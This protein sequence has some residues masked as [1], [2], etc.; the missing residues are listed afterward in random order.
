MSMTIS[1]RHRVFAR[2]RLSPV[3]AVAVLPLVVVLVTAAEVAKTAKL[4]SS[5]EATATLKF[6]VWPPMRVTK[7]LYQ[8]NSGCATAK[9]DMWLQR[10]AYS[11]SLFMFESGSSERADHSTDENGTTVI[12]GGEGCRYR[13]RI[14]RAD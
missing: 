4:S 8:D 1:R 9:F 2:S 3:I 11:Y 14:D 10:G 5:A 7:H 12:I 6:S 13:V